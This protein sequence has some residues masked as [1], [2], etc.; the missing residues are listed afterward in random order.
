MNPFMGSIFGCSLPPHAEGI[1]DD[2]L[3]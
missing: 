1:D 2:G 3:D